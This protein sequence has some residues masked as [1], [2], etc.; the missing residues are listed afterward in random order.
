M[1]EKK[2]E[3]SMVAEQIQRNVYHNGKWDW[4][5]ELETNE[6]LNPIQAKIIERL[7]DPNFQPFRIDEAFVD[8]YRKVKPP[9]GFGG[10][11]ELVYMRTYSR[12]MDDGKNELWTDTT[13]RVIN[14]TYNLQK[15]WIQ[16]RGL[17]WS[18]YKAQGSA[19]EMFDRM[20][21][22]K[23]LPPGRGIWAMGSEITEERGLYAALNNCAF[24]STEN[25]K[26][27]LS[28]P[29]KFLMDMSMLG[30]GVGFD[31]K[32]AG[33]LMVKG[34][35]YRREPDK[36]IIPDTREGWVESVGRLVES[37]FLGINPSEFNYDLVR[38]V[39]NLIGGFGGKSSGPE[40][41]EELHQSLETTLT[42]QIG[43]PLG[44]R[45]IVDI[46]NLIG[47]CVVAGNVRRTAE[48]ALG[49]PG[50]EEFLNLKNYD[51]NPERAAYGWT[52]NNSVFAELGMDYHEVA[53]RIR[54]NGEPGLIWLENI[55]QF[56]RMNGIPDYKD[57]R[58]KGCNPC[59]EQSLEDKE[60]CNLVETFPNNHESKE[61][62]LRTLKF[63]YMYAKTVTL[64]E[65]HWPETNR[66][67]LRNRRI[68][69]SISGV[70][71]F[72]VD[73]NLGEL[74]EWLKEGY[75]TVQH[76]D[77]VY[78]DWMTVPKSIKTTSVKPSGTVSSVAGATSGMHW[79]ISEYCIR[80]MRLSNKSELIQ[81]IRDAGYPVEED[82]YDA[83]SLVVE[84]PVH[85][86][87]GIRG[88]D[89]VSMWEQFEMVSFLQE[90]WSDNQVSSTIKFNPDLRIDTATGINELEEL[91]RLTRRQFGLTELTRR[92]KM[93][94]EY[95]R[96]LNAVEIAES[97]PDKL[98]SRQKELI[99]SVKKKYFMMTTSDLARKS[100]LEAK[101]AKSE[102]DE[103]EHALDHFQYSLKGI[104]MLPNETNIY[105]QAPYEPISKEEYTR[106]AGEVKE[107]DFS[108]I[109]NSKSTPDKFCSNDVC[110]LKAEQGSLVK[111]NGN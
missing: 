69:C 86:G 97:N 61:D 3:N 98:N 100:E 66:V 65:T 107:I 53:E 36:F 106:R 5:K 49:E 62:F 60:L 104:S 15:R 21:H 68:G 19:Q 63:A 8:K 14:G 22:M 6:Y 30:V 77:E 84:F 10:F 74:R 26:E 13:E 73:R 47:K 64:G 27:E 72:A 58:A 12:I 85:I 50:D 2:G 24:V 56:G 1:G 55:R 78:S 76:Y 29:F 103:I 87:E 95:G 91:R 7:H 35:D 33:Q 102:A 17:E 28:L 34:P 52:S 9:F 83:S 46:Q 96:Y 37:Y 54:A 32:G 4:K 45:A 70:A 79:P 108:E 42:A 59:V 105:V 101:L 90:N 93:N 11:G 89:E 67:L 39:G 23:F 18:D 71:Q 81:P 44:S 111:E 75:D 80:R 43:R 51:R 38:P 16:E 41:L 99:D 109:R 40:P 92:G 20:F 57:H 31:T 88:E 48:I 110:E 82:S 25:I 94:E